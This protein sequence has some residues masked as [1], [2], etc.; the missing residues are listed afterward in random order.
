VIQEGELENSPNALRLKLEAP[1]NARYLKLEATSL[2][3]GTDMVLTE[4][5]AYT[6]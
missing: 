5:E 3:G 1:C 2:H 6:R 4:I